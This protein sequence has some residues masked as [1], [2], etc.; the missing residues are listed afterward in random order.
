ML[1]S[2]CPHALADEAPAAIPP[3]VVAPAAAPQVLDL[4]TARGMAVTH[5]PTV[6]AARAALPCS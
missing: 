3:Q 5:Q 1:L 6:A 4:S 2:L